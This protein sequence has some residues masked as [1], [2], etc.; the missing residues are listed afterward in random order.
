MGKI[1]ITFCLLLSFASSFAN[2]GIP[3]PEHRTLKVVYSNEITAQNADDVFLLSEKIGNTDPTLLKANIDHLSL[4]EKIKLSKSAYKQ[5]KEAKA[6]GEKPSKAVIYI[7]CAIVPPVAVGIWTDWSK[8]T[9]YNL[10]WTCAFGL[11]GV[12]HAYMVVSR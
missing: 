6:V 9:I 12:V 3:V 2:A 5:A 1:L 4:I 7:L 10:I 11:P 8:P